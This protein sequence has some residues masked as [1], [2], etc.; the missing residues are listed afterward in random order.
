MAEINFN[1]ALQPKQKE[2][3]KLSLEFP[4][5]AFGGAKGGGKSFFVRAR[6]LYRRLQYPF[7]TGCIIRQ[8][9]G[10]LW[11]NHIRQFFIEYPE[12]KTWYSAERKTIEYPN[13]S[14]TQFIYL[15][16]EK[17]ALVYQG[18]SYDDISFDE[19]TQHPY[20][21]FAMM[22]SC[23]RL[24]NPKL[25]NKIKPS[26]ILTCNPGGIGHDWVKR[27]FID[28][29]FNDGDYSDRKSVV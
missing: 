20:E 5:F 15:R 6:E 22:S 23:N 16:N 19:A 2:A 3:F 17:D 24:S 28:R 11:D 21:S 29:N 18:R 8:T 9:Y 14:V 10:E 1:I 4:V 27:L 26:M 7:S 25:Q 13:G 12:L